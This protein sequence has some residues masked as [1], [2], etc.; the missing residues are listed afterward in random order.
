[1]RLIAIARNT[2]I[3]AIRQPVYGVLLLITFVILVLDLP[4]SNWTMGRG[5]A[6]YHETDQ[7]FMINLGLSTLLVSGLFISA[8][9]A[10][11]VISR[12]IEDKTIL[13]VLSKPV[14]RPIII[15]GKFVGVAAGMIV[16]YYLSSLVFLMTVRH[17]VMPTAA[18][19]FD[20]P[21][22]VLGGSAFV[23]SILLAVF[24]NYFFNWHFIS[25]AV[26]FLVV[27]LSLAM[28]V[29]TFVGKGWKAVPP[30]YDVPPKP[31]QGVARVKIKQGYSI[32]DFLKRASKKGFSAGQIDKEHNTLTVRFSIDIKPT[33]A[34]KMLKEFDAVKEA[35]TID[36]TPPAITSQLLIAIALQLLAV[37]IFAAVAVAASTRVGQVMTLLICVGF[38]II[39]STSYYLFGRFAQ[40]SILAKLAYLLWSNFTFFYAMDALMAGKSIPLDY[41]GLA[42]LYAICHIVAI[43]GIGMVL[44]HRRELAAEAEGISTSAPSLVSLLAWSGRA[45][46]LVAGIIA[47]SIIGRGEVMTIK[48]AVYVVALLAAAIGGWILAGWFGGGVKWMYILVATCAA[49][50]TV[51]GVVMILI[52]ITGTVPIRAY[53]TMAAGAAVLL[54]LYMP[55]TRH[56]FH[57]LRNQHRVLQ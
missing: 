33:K 31:K 22:I 5:M 4:L 6:E 19:P 47:V 32:D 25:S 54:I 57:L 7:Q 39:G 48:S 27:L 53:M 45:A 14:A 20:W 56:Y 24:C 23:L 8:F 35:H 26:G 51:W 43:L 3:E 50:V 17:R 11:G 29:I 36:K 46:A 15:L 38:F 37:M 49:A 21:V 52:N 9:T 10:S 42:A 40:S 55:R 30:G 34:V 16:A 2:F 1:V 13:T 12:E 18:D 41:V 44:F 28:G